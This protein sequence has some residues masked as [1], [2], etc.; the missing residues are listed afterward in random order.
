VQT[1][2]ARVTVI[3]AYTRPSTIGPVGIRAKKRVAAYARV[4]TDSEEQ[5]N[6]YEAQVDHY[7]KYI[8][9]KEEWDLVEVYADE[10]ISA[11]NTKKRDGFNRMIADALKGKIDMIITKSVSRFARNTVDT[12]TTVRKLKEKGVEVYF[13]KENIY[14]LDSKGELLIT[15]MSSLA[16]EES[17]S[18]SENVKWGQ[19]KRFADGKVSLP[20]KQFLGYEKGE[21]GL[22]K[23]VEKE[24]AVV[25]MI[26]SLFLEGNTPYGISRILTQ[27][28]I[29]SPAGKQKWQPGTVESILT[30]EKYKGD[31]LLQK[32]FTVD[33]LT[34]KMKTNEGEVPQYYV[35]NSHSAIISSEVFELVQHEMK[36]R[37]EA[38]R[39]VNGL[40]CFS[41]KIIC[42]D[43]GS[44][45]GSKLWHSQDKYRRTVWQCN[46]KFQNEH[47]CSTP[48]LYEAEL[49]KAFVDA[50]NS[51]I[52]NKEE[53]LRGYTEIIEAL[54]DTADLDMEYDRLQSENGDVVQLMKECV[55]EN[56][57]TAFDQADYQRRYGP[58]LERYET[59]KCNL[60][61]ISD[62]RQER[63]AK[64]ENVLRFL[65]ILN[66]SELLTEFDEG[67][68]RTMV[69]TVTVKSS[70][71]IIL[72][73]K[74]GTELSWTL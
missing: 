62:R 17:R 69:E 25:R 50:F 5:L 64:R 30:N 49:Q 23:I 19:R 16:Q 18:L 46:Q 28:G 2:T 15:I 9:E 1:N 29:P 39:Y 45:Y 74:D 57:N 31:A 70:H 34:K 33:F 56:A 54:T 42:G 67:L 11:T 14:T 44:T 43:C 40:S 47:K 73:L 53:I 35:E 3:P 65:E 66:Q 55:Q 12:L 10:G 37:K 36:K 6:S 51:Y 7:T 8:T 38:G 58:L 72:A 59:I 48:H 27:K 52:Y 60:A 61:R 32:N 41:G 71:K 4:S 22:P 13:E 20:Y 26:Y 24:A 68:W 63:A 21:D